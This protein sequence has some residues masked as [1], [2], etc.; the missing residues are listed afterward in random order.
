MPISLPEHENN[1]SE[2]AEL[3]GFNLLAPL[4]SVSPEAFIPKNKQDP[5]E[6]EVCNF[7]LA[8][9]LV[10]N[11][12]KD[13][14]W[15]RASLTKFGEKLDL[16]KLSAQCGQYSGLGLHLLRLLYGSMNELMVLIRSH[17]AALGHPL[18]S[19]IIHSLNADERKVWAE[20]LAMSKGEKGEPGSL[21]DI[22]HKIRNKSAFHYWDIKPLGCGYAQFFSAGG[23]GTE[24]ALFSRGNTILASR[25]YFADAAVSGYFNILVKTAQKDF[26]EH[27]NKF[28]NQSDSVLFK[29][30]DRFI[31]KRGYAWSS[32]KE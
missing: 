23:P 31:A 12:F 24:G 18:F 28:I 16:T 20:I 22:M 17:P 10:Y 13:I 15:A 30:V 2:N 9:A 5:K 21:Q 19:E 3:L 14:H 26:K 8:L 32:P 11:D 1:S 4:S 25:F 29:I 6:Q 27:L 7:V